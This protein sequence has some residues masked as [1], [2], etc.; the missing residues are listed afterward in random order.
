MNPGKVLPTPRACVEVR[1][2]QRHVA[3][4]DVTG[5]PS[6]LEPGTRDELAEIVRAAARDR[7]PLRVT[8]RAEPAGPIAAGA[9]V[10]STRRLDRVL[11]HEP[12]DLTLTAECGLS[13]AAAQEPPLRSPPA[14]RARPA[15]SRRRRSGA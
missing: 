5:A 10:I 3:A 15:G 7:I 2:S 1:A 12:G 8:G 9:R 14:R 6:F 11:A 4:T 13:V